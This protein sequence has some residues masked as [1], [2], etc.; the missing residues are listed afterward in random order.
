MIWID[1]TTSDGTLGGHSLT[2][3]FAL[4]DD[5]KQDWIVEGIRWFWLARLLRWWH[6]K[7]RRQLT[8]D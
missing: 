2:R 7:T 4:F 3:P 5:R 8:D 1:G 6:R